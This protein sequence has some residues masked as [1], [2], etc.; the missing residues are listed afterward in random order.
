MRPE[1]SA[2]PR[3]PAMPPEEA[4]RLQNAT[5][6]VKKQSIQLLNVSPSFSS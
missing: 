6:T 3:V 1:F 5:V 2:P 4:K